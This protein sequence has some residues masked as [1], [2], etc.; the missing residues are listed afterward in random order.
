MFD[1]SDLNFKNM[2]HHTDTLITIPKKQYSRFPKNLME[3]SAKTNNKFLNDNLHIIE[4]LEYR[5]KGSTIPFKEYQNK[6][7]GK[8]EILNHDLYFKH[9]GKIYPKVSGSANMGN[10]FKSFRVI[11]ADLSSGSNAAHRTGNDG[12]IMCPAFTGGTVGAL[13]DRI[14]VNLFASAGNERL[15]CYSDTD[16]L[17]RET[18]SIASANGFN[19]QSVTEFSLTGTAGRI[20]LQVNNSSNDVYDSGATDTNNGVIPYTYGA[21]PDPLASNIQVF[22]VRNMKIGHS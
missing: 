22:F 8:T 9:E 14:A 21:F 19:W 18:G 12:I 5:K 1:I 13:Y 20:A 17:Y 15:A 3:Y 2:P 6:I 11:G 10:P 4:E 16:V 7:Y